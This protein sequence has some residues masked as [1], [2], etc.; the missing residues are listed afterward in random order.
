MKDLSESQHKTFADWDWMLSM[1]HESYDGFFCV[2]YDHNNVETIAGFEYPA[3][4]VTFT[5]SGAETRQMDR[6]TFIQWMQTPHSPFGGLG[7]TRH[8]Q[9]LMQQLRPDH[10]KAFNSE[11]ACSRL[12]EILADG[13]I[14]IY[15][16]DNAMRNI[17][18]L[19]T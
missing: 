9:E 8:W 5:V 18:W 11:L 1:Y 6:R 17:R 7:Q 3:P 19:Y 15:D 12:E 4:S 14:T 10:H 2:N 13:K 16:L